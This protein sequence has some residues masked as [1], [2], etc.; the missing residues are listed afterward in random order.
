[1]SEIEYITRKLVSLAM[2][3]RLMESLREV[4]GELPDE[5]LDDIYWKIYRPVMVTFMKTLLGLISS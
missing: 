4:A 2:E 3:K 1:M 5:V